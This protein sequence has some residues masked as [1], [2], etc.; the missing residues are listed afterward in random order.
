MINEFLKR[1]FY[2]QT[3]Q[4]PDSRYLLIP[5][6][7]MNE[8]IK[9]RIMELERLAEECR[10]DLQTKYYAVFE[11]QGKHKLRI[12]VCGDIDGDE[13]DELTGTGL[14]G[15]G[16]PPRLVIDYDGPKYDEDFYADV[17]YLW[18]RSGASRN[19]NGAL[20][21]KAEYELNEEIER[22][23]NELLGQALAR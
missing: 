13:E 4:S 20:F 7:E 3:D 10:V 16:V 22:K 17:I 9:K 2:L 1:L 12:W 19:A 21:N 14:S 18:H 15:E 5:R 11:K 6:E 23:L 8:T